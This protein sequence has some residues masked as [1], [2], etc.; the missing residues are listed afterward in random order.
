VVKELN[1]KDA[2][3]LYE[4]IGLGERLAPLVARR[5]QPAQGARAG[6]NASGP[7]MIAGTEGLAGDLRALLLSDPERSHH[8][9]LER[10]PRRHDSSAELR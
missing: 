7:L 10:R 2:D 5:L 4:K 8:G 1:F 9:V 6:G 3:E